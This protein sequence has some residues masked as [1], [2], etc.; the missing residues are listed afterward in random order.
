METEKTV[1]MVF[2]FIIVLSGFYIN[3]NYASAAVNKKDNTLIWF[4]V[5]SPMALVI[6]L[7][8]YFFNYGSF[9]ASA[10]TNILG[11][12]LFFTGIIIRWIAVHTLGSSFTVQVGVKT[13]QKLKTDGVY[14]FIR[15]PSYTGLLMYNI[16]LG[17]LQHNWISIMILFLLPFIA[18][19]NRI[20]FEEK[21]LLNHF[22]CDY[23]NYSKVTKKLIPGIF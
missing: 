3:L 5:L 1:V 17:F 13:D 23:A 21:V 4:R 7:I 20:V 2:A 6:S 22:N 15:H 12:L 10:F 19:I 14:R 8:L 9:K 16:G 18:V 11:G